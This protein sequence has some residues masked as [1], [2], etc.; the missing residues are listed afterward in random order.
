MSKEKSNLSLIIVTRYAS[1]MLELALNSYFLNSYLDNELIVVADRPSWQTLKVLQERKIPHYTVP[2]A[3]FFLSCNFG[4]WKAHREYVGFVNDDVYFGPG[5]DVALMEIAAPNVQAAVFRYE[6]P[7]GYCCG[8]D[9]KDIKSFKPELLDEA[10]E[11]NKH[12]MT[13]CSSGFPTT[14]HRETFF[15]YHGYTFHGGQGSGHELHWVNRVRKDD[16]AARHLRTFKSGIFHFGS[17]G[18]RDNI[19][20]Y[21]ELGFRRGVKLCFGCGKWEFPQAIDEL[22]RAWVR[23]PEFKEIYERG[24]WLVQIV[25]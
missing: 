17:G 3:H 11:K 21:S 20:N 18:N 22:N 2:F 23:T 5:W 7:N 6:C 15:K 14:H 12:K 24:Y 8:Y 1:D 13:N 4:G 16:P 19:D 25:K 10:I 9:H